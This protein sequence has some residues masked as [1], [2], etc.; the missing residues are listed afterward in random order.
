MEAIKEENSHNYVE[1]NW[2]KTFIKDYIKQLGLDTNLRETLGTVTQR[3][4][5]PNRPVSCLNIQDLC[6]WSFWQSV[7]RC[8]Q[9]RCQPLCCWRDW[10]HTFCLH[11]AHSIVSNTTGTH[12]RAKLIVSSLE[13]FIFVLPSFPQCCSKY[14][15]RGW[16]HFRLQRLYFVWVCS[17]LQSF[18]WFAELLCSVHHKVQTQST[19][20]TYQ[21]FA[22][23]SILSVLFYVLSLYS[24]SLP[25][26][27]GHQ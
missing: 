23:S 18:Y 22:S 13:S 16:T 7:R 12:L 27:S 2:D 25:P 20:W 1:R 26:P 11:A 21:N 8:V 19:G 24:K 6:G 4:K 10:S 9:L 3:P 15:D 5:L 14:R 17:E